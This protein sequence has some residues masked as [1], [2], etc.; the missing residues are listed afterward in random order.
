VDRG[1]VRLRRPQGDAW[2]KNNLSAYGHLRKGQQ[3]PVVVTWDE[4]DNGENNEYSQARVGTPD[5]KVLAIDPDTVKRAN[6]RASHP[7]RHDS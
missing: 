4:E 3:Q 6:R 2:L 1:Q 5:P 7:R